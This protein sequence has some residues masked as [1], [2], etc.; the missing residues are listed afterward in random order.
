MDFVGSTAYVFGVTLVVLPTIVQK[1]ISRVDLMTGFT[2]RQMGLFVI[3][4]WIPVVSVVMRTCPT[5]TRK[6]FVDT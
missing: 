3:H 5:C 1:I 4:V 2:R 6:I